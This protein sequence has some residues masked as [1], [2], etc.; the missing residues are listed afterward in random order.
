MMVT[1]V[2]QTI[3]A[4][5]ENGLLRPLEPLRLEEHVEVQLTVEESG[6]ASSSADED[7]DDPFAD[8]RI[9][10]GIPDLAENFDDYRFG[11]RQP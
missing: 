8:I 1:T 4:I 6:P 2:T 11:R 3:R 9:D 5:Y 7:D 10:T